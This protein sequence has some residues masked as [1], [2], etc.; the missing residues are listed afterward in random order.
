MDTAG[1]SWQP[2]PSGRHQHRYWDGSRWTDH[3]ADNGVTGIDPLLAPPPPIVATPPPATVPAVGGWRPG[4]IV[5]L[6]GAVAIGVG[7][8]AP[9][10]EASAGV[11]SRSVSGTDGDG[12]I[13]LVLAVVVL[14]LA[15]VT[16]TPTA[17]RGLLV[18]AGLCAAG[19]AGIG[20]YDAVNVNDAAR[21]AEDL[22][23]LV[24]AS[25]GWGL[26]AVIAG[27]VLGVIGAFV[28][29]NELPKPVA[30]VAAQPPPPTA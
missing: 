18:L 14:L 17:R 20:I 2:D 26:Y 6:L 25:V 22:S 9:W 16:T 23:S 11:F 13:T 5:L 8:V 24:E 10:A 3:V 7:S 4:T 29:S 28:R 1:A 27:G 15:L 21:R 19:A 12:V 30:S